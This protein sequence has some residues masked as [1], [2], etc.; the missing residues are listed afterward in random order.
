[1]HLCIRSH[2]SLDTL[3]ILCAGPLMPD[4][5]LAHVDTHLVVEEGK[6]AEVGYCSIV[7]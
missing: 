6:I 1:V 5:E 4:E 3:H 2:L 7:S